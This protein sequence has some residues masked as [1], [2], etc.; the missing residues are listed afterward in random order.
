MATFVAC[1]RNVERVVLCSGAL[2]LHR[3]GVEHW[4]AG[5]PAQLHYTLDDPFKTDGSVESVLRSVNGAGAIAEYIQYPG[6]GHLFTNPSL[7]GEYDAQSAAA[8][9]AHV[10]T[11]LDV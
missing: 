9:W 7:P 6:S 10:T 5:M 2:P 8:L 3:I 11:F 4:P 1:N